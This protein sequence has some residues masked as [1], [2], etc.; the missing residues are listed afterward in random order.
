MPLVDAL[1]LS[2]AASF[3]IA[4]PAI[5]AELGRPPKDVPLFVDIKNVWGYKL[6]PRE[7]FWLGFLI[8]LLMAALFGALYFLLTQFGYVRPYRLGGLLTY[9][10]GFYLLVGLVIFPVFRLGLFGRKEG[11]WVWFELLVVHH[12]L[13]FLMWAGVTAFPALMP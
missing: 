5:V 4:L 6:N 2:L 8:H 1:F 7:V 10:T 9:A 12:L 11:P 3:V 13:G